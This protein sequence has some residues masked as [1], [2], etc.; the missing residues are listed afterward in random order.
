M[1]EYHRTS[2]TKL[3][4]DRSVT[5]HVIKVQLEGRDSAYAAGTPAREALL[6]EGH[7]YTEITL[8]KCYV[9]GAW[10]HLQYCQLI[11]FN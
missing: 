6:A 4:L 3:Y 1:Y 2:T 9:A 10:S 8:K 11:K 5:D 7:C